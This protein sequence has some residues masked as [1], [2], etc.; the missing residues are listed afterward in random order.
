[1]ADSAEIHGEHLAFYDLTA[2]Y[3]PCSYSKS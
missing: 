1:M 3:L 2:N